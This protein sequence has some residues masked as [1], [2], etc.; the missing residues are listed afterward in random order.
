VMRAT[1]GG[2]VFDA[3]AVREEGLACRAFLERALSTP[4]PSPSPAPAEPGTSPW[5]RTV[6]ITHFAPSLR[7]ADPRYG[8][9][10]AT[11]SFC[12]ADEDL[13]VKADLWLHGHLHCRH[14][15]TVQRPDGRGV[16]V[17]CQARGLQAKG[18]HIGLEPGRLVEV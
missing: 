16:R 18:E 8:A 15:Y 1:R 6:V 5:D 14:D 2:Q 10:P 9:A 12:N 4:S 7:S 17:W 13:V 11:A 3:A